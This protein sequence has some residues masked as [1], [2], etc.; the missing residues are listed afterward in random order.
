MIMIFSIDFFFTVLFF[1][2]VQW[3][4]SYVQGLLN[5]CFK[6]LLSWCWWLWCLFFSY[7]FYILLTACPSFNTGT[8]VMRLCPWWWLNSP[9]ALAHFRDIQLFTQASSDLCGNLHNIQTELNCNSRTP[10]VHLV[11]PAHSQTCMKHE[12]VRNKPI[13]TTLQRFSFSMQAG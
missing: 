7:F 3:L 13:E 9:T 12:A 5:S 4:W 10:C 2:H 1:M 6:S 8:V 11:S